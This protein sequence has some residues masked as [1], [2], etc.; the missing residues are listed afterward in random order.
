M[1]FIYVSSFPRYF[2]RCERVQKLNNKIMPIFL[3][4]RKS[5]YN[6]VGYRGTCV[7][8]ISC[9]DHRWPRGLS[10]SGE[11]KKPLLSHRSIF[12]L[13]RIVKK[14]NVYI[15][16]LVGEC[17]LVLIHMNQC[18]RLPKKEWSSVLIDFLSGRNCAFVVFPPARGFEIKG[19]FWRKLLK[20][21][22]RK[23][24]I[25]IS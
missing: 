17:N 25:H 19:N 12:V 9:Y 24:W 11:E 15:K 13:H 3:R 16:L 4:H 7:G 22:K 23:W 18:F 20:G 14:I 5:E 1:F 10:S 8:S 21:K 6:R 2:R